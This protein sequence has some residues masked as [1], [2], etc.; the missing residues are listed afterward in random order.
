M[1]R[2]VT[3]AAAD[4]GNAIA[5]ASGSE[6]FAC[7]NADLTITLHR[8][9]EGEW[10]GVEPSIFPEAHGIGVSESIL[11]DDAGRIGLGV[12]NVLIDER[13]D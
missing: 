7:I 13:P 2:V 11:Y 6:R 5:T 8:L 10:V 4:F 9:P 1:R 12:Q 3:T